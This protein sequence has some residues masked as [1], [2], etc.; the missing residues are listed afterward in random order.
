MKKIQ[1]FAAAGLLIAA[2]AIAK[3][4]A[5]KPQA[6]W[7]ETSASTM[8][9]AVAGAG[10]RDTKVWNSTISSVLVRDAKGDVLID[11]GFGPNAEAQMGELPD[12]GRAFGMQVVSGA[13]DRKSILDVLSTVHES[14]AQVTRILITHAHYDHLGGA[15]QLAAPVYVSSAEAAWMADQ[16]AH[17]TITPPSLIAAVEPRLKVLA[18]DSGAYLGFDQSKDLYGDGTIVAVPLPGHTPG[19]QGVFLTLGQHKVFLIGD[20]ADILEAA[21]RGLPKSPPIRANTDF[22][23]ELADLTTKRI[24]DFHRAHPEVAL[25]PAHDRTAF[26]AVFGEPSTC[27]SK[28]QSAQEDRHAQ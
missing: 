1:I 18:Y 13:K 8:D 9:A 17:P 14:P 19:S 26:A 3:G 16:A 24:A 11:S 5:D 4:S 25:V 20:A 15:T 6:C 12:A 2:S 7:L 22:S 28:F 10:I 27:I 23:P 21:E